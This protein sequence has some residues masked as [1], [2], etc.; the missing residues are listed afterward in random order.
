MTLWIKTL[1]KNRESG[2][3]K[4]NRYFKLERGTRQGEPISAYLFIIVLEIAFTLIKTNNNTEGL[5]IFNHNF[6]YTAYADNTT[7]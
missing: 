7:F 1:L 4:T 5:N 2:V 6:L 3:L